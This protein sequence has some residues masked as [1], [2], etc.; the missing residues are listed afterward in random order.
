MLGLASAAFVGVVALALV[1]S[2]TAT[3][4]VGGPPSK[5]ERWSKPYRGKED[6][7]SIGQH[8]M[9]VV[10]DQVIRLLD[11][12]VTAF[13]LA[14]GKA[15]WSYGDGELC[16]AGSFDRTAGYVWRGKDGDCADLYRVDTGDGAVTAHADLLGTLGE[17]NDPPTTV[18][19]GDALVVLARNRSEGDVLVALSA[20]TPTKQLWRTKPDVFDGMEPDEFDLLDEITVTRNGEA[21]VVG[22]SSVASYDV[23]TGRREWRRQVEAS[24]GFIDGSPLVAGDE[25]GRLTVFDQETGHTQSS[26]TLDGSFLGKHDTVTIAHGMAVYQAGDASFSDDG[27]YGYDLAT[28]ERRW[29]AKKWTVGLDLIGPSRSG[30][31]VFLLGVNLRYG[32]NSVYRV[33]PRTGHLV[34]V[35]GLRS[36]S[37]IVDHGS[38][39]TWT[40][41]RLI[42]EFALRGDGTLADPV[43][44]APVVYG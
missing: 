18:R 40:G 43:V 11:G 10:D 7:V 3:G 35:A 15:N 39:M 6:P 33:D 14:T 36:R 28:G 17:S 1:V 30:D 37:G 20:T 31:Q 16:G 22:G 4:V 8:G 24:A 12:T 23:S 27:V 34:A 21:V 41:S 19:A 25:D 13:D 29:T 38:A 26:F 5:D 44:K 32:D 42:A 2:L 9:W